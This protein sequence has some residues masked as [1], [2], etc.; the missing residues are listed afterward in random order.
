MV[1]SDPSP[2]CPSL[3]PGISIIVPAYNSEQTLESLAERIAGAV[4][5]VGES[6]EILLINDG[7]RDGSWAVIER[8]A[9]GNPHIR[10]IDLM[11][12][13]GQHNALLC[14]LRAARYAVAVTLDDDLQNPPE[15]IPRLLAKLEEG[16][17][18]VYGKPG[19]ERHGILRDLASWITKL[20]L[21][22]A[23]GADTARSV[24][25]FRALR[26]ELR[27]AFA[28]YSNPYVN[29]DVLLTW[30]TQ[31]FGAV[32]VRHEQRKSG[33]SNYT[34]RKLIRHALNMVT[35][36]S[37]LPLQLA[38]IIGLTFALFGFGVLV[39]VL[40]RY[41]IQGSKVEGFPF[42]AS[43]IAIF[44]GAQLFAIGI[45]GEYL[46]RI[47]VRSQD[48]PTYTIRRSS[49]M[50]LNRQGAKTPRETPTEKA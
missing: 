25:A 34:V 18:V 11:R 1:G 36:F 31:R 16:L 10:G 13:S 5:S 2:A 38:G 29:L 48:R 27:E 19:R 4:A 26:T 6:F 21:Q 15:E 40:G 50:Q 44:S 45:I 32:N 3:S 23:M 30:A 24:S 20:V 39:Y 22:E 17:D 33:D 14:G 9:T 46:A 7:S 12:N 43:T 47:H 49:E 41:V 37:V 42:L 35:G 8:L 28:T